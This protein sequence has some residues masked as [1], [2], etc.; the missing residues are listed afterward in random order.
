[1][2]NLNQIEQEF[3]AH[4]GVRN[5][6]PINTI[7]NLSQQIGD[8]KKSKFEKSLKLA[9]IVNKANDWYKSEEAKNLMNEEGID[10]VNVEIFAER[11]FGW[12]KSYFFKMVKAGKLLEENPQVVTK[13]KRECTQAENN[14]ESTSRSLESL[15]KFAKAELTEGNAQ[16]I[17]RPK[18]I[19]TLKGTG[20]FAHIKFEI[21]PDEVKTSNEVAQLTEAM[22]LINLKISEL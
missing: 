13:F 10:W 19:L 1:M 4:T 9:K 17:E 11:V 5:H 22:N 12:K 6:V 14:G 2:N 7:Q 15:H 8:A 18:A 16:V 3:L 20:D 21:F